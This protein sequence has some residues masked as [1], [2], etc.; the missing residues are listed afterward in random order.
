MK[1]SSLFSPQQI[2]EKIRFRQ[3]TSA[4]RTLTELHRLPDV[5]M[6][7]R[8]LRARGFQARHIFDVGA[9]EG[10]NLSSFLA[11]WPGATVVAFEP[12]DD[13]AAALRAKFRGR[14]VTV[15]GS[16]VGDKDI[17]DATFY[18]DKNA[19][20]V[21]FSEPVGG[22]KQVLTKRMTRLDTYID[23]TKT[24]VPDFLQIDTLSFEYQILKGLGGYLP[25][26]DAIMLQLNFIEVFHGVTLAHEVID[27]LGGQGFVMY[28]VCDVHRRPLDQALWQMD[29]LF[30]QADSYL[31]ENKKWA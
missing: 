26:V 18:A 28:D 23:S 19:S 15:V 13:K 11:L 30:V 6:S 14:D 17:D 10:E 3:F 27:Y 8:R 1:L 4:V 16:L 9:Y 5:D 29:C 25:A 7:L 22:E 20:S 31:R 21:H 2:R 12:L 24:A